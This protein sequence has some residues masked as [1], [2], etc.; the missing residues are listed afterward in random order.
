MSRSHASSRSRNSVSLRPEVLESRSL[1]TGGA[2]NTFALVPGNV[3]D[4]GGTAQV[5]ITIAPPLFTLPKQ[6]MVLGIDVVPKTNSSLTPLIS[7]VDNPHN[8][9]VP[10][11]IHSVLKS[12]SKPTRDPAA[13]SASRARDSDFHPITSAYSPTSDEPI[14][15]PQARSPR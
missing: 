6:K 10:Q 13:A 9:I 11:A 2:G 8:E 12:A 15:R 4:P 3:A 1:M 14:P 7:R 5:P